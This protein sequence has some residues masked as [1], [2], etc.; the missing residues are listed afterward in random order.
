MLSTLCTGIMGIVGLLMVHQTSLPMNKLRKAML[1]GLCIAFVVCY[2]FLPEL[3]TLSALDK[4]SLLI[5][6]VLGLLAFSVMFVCRKGLAQLNRRF[7]KGIFP[8]RRKKN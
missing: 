3:F 4:P 1:V 2:F 5:L 7:A 8:P 6:V